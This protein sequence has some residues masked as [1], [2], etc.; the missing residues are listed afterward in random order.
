M[1][2]LTKDQE[3]ILNRLTKGNWVQTPKGVDI[4]GSINFNYQELTKLPV[5]FNIIHDNFYC[6]FNKFTTL[7]GAPRKVYGN[8]ACQGNPLI[9]LEGAPILVNG[10]F[11][12]DCKHH[13]D[14]PYKLW[15]MKRKLKQ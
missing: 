5:K 4:L 1:D 2:K 13:N 15:L 7:E 9:S 10:L 14:P 8:F 6:C 12:C 3:W 11:W